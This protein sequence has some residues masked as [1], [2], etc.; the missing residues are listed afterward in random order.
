MRPGS[1]ATSNPKPPIAIIAGRGQLPLILAD[2]LGSRAR[3]IALRGYADLGPRSHATIPFGHFGAMIDQGLATGARQIVFIG[4][5]DRPGMAG[6]DLDAYSQENLDLQKLR[7]GDDTALRAIADLFEAR[8]LTVCGPLDLLPGLAMPVGCLTHH[9]PDARARTDLKRG[10]DVA[11]TLGQVDVGQSVVVQQGLVL[12]VEGIEGTD[13]LIQRSAS[14]ARPGPRPVL[15]K[16]A[17]PEQ[18]MRLDVPTIGPQTMDTLHQANFA[19]AFIQAGY[20][21]LVDRPGVVARADTAG[22]FLEGIEG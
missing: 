11:R 3:I 8:G 4:G 19:G 18:D 21:M 10:F 5:L 7:E 17:K 15:V 16:I 13:A 2:A 14:L 6:L 22:L 1:V 20:A 12:A 9:T